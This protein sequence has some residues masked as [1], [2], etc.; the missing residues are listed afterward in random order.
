MQSQRERQSWYDVCDL[1]VF[2][3]YFFFSFGP[4]EDNRVVDR[5]GVGFRTPSLHEPVNSRP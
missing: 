2:D 4:F 5:L 3:I 1:F